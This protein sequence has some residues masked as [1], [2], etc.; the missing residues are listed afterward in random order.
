MSN[1]GF[2]SFTA[3]LNMFKPFIG[4]PKKTGFCYRMG[5]VMNG[6][7]QFS[8]I[9]EGKCPG[10]PPSKGVWFKM[11][12]EIRGSSAIISLDGRHLVTANPH[13]HVFARGGW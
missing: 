7:V 6:V 11:L 12:V 5:Y 2:V 8:G 13:F 9:L 1:E 3:V 4:R 10:G